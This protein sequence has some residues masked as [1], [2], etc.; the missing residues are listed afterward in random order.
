MTVGRRIV[1]LTALVLF[2]I[3]QIPTALA[4]STPS[5]IALR[6]ITGLCG[7]VGV[8]NGGGTV[9]DLF[10]T[11][12]RATVL[13]FY[14][15]G[16]L[17][18][19]SLGPFLGGLINSQLSWRWIFWI[20][21]I[22]STVLTTNCYFFLLESR[23]PIILEKRKQRLEAKNPDTTYKVEGASDEPVGR[24]ILSVRLRSVCLQH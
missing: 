22:V 1:F 11:N 18:G 23:A 16:P 21:F 3:L 15:L 6:T 2:T 24:K 7:S 20:L 4:Q 9:S 19:P 13:G 5:L 8:A 14:L 17:L 12:E 10:E